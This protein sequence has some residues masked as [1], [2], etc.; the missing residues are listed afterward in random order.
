MRKFLTLN[1]ASLIIPSKVVLDNKNFN[2]GNETL[3]SSESR[4][5]DDSMSLRTNSCWS[6]DTLMSNVRLHF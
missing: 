6:G 3:T 2:P 4:N 5:N 1:T